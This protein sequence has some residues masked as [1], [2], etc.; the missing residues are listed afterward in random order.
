M[1]N[2]ILNPINVI[3]QLKYRYDVEIGNGKRSCVR[4]LIEKDDTSS[5][6]LIILFLSKINSSDN[7][8]LV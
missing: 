1:K 8:N 3:N 5:N 2:R 7:S 6:K 4:K